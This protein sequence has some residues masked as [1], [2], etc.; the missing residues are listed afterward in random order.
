MGLQYLGLYGRAAARIM[1][2]HDSTTKCSRAGSSAVSFVVEKDHKRMP[3]LPLTQK[4]VRNIGYHI[5]TFIPALGVLNRSLS[6]FPQLPVLG[7]T[8]GEKHFGKRSW[9][10]L[11]RFRTPFQWPF[12]P[13]EIWKRSNTILFRYRNSRSPSLK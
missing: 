2:T 4:A 9:T 8:A 6:T 7:R 11:Q 13:L 3:L 10:Q 12:G 5:F 1:S